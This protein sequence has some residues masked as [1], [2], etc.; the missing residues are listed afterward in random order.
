VQPY[1][2]IML[3]VL[4]A[5]GL[6][7]VLKGM[8]WQIASVAS[9]V[10]SAMVAVHFSPTLAPYISSQAPW[11][12]YLAMAILYIVT[13]LV[14]WLVFRPI[15]GLID[16]VKLHDFDR[17]IGGLIGLAKGVLLCLV[18][19]FFAVTLSESTR[20]MVLAARSGYYI[21]RFTQ[22]AVPILPQEVRDLLGKYIEEMERKLDPNTPA[23]PGAL[24]QK[25]GTKPSGNTAPQS[26]ETNLMRDA[27]SA[28]SKAWSSS[29]QSAPNPSGQPAPPP[30]NR[31]S[32]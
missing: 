19:T 10:V 21:A 29:N 14:V 15:A 20:Q 23:E 22:Q 3:V 28:F 25:S 18:I 32:R 1:D 9:I 7:G 30:A 5:G 6:F 12:R 24:D 31:G 27:A 16:K 11:N 2:I 26:K 8:A 13:S 4:V 17:Q